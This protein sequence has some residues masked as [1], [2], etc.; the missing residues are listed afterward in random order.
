MAETFN[1]KWENFQSNASNSFGLLRN[2]EYLHDVTLVGDDH[3]QVSAHR[4]VLSAC[5]EYFKDIF[6]YNSKPNAHP[7]LCLSGVSSEDLNNVMDYIYN[8]E[9]QLY[10]ASLQR[11]LDVA[12]RLKLGG[13][14]DMENQDTDDNEN[15]QEVVPNVKK[16]FDET[17]EAASSNSEELVSPKKV[18]SPKNSKIVAM[19]SEKLIEG[20]EGSTTNIPQKEVKRREISSV[21]SKFQC[22]QCEK[23]FSTN[24]TVH[25]HIRSVH[26]GVKIDCNQCDKQ[27]AKTSHL[28]RHVKKVHNEDVKKIASDKTCEEGTQLVKLTMN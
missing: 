2:E 6:K 18:S 14:M 17:E 12:Q 5:S 10:Q 22:P 27:F 24:S 21:G 8:G 23:Y 3:Q 28:A 13:I 16:E 9:I 1:L 26:E 20:E 11:F 7:I 4:L 15:P 25:Q 19:S